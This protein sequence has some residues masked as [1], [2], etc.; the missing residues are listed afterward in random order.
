[1][2][3]MLALN[4]PQFDWVKTRFSKK[5]QP[6]PPIYQPEV[7]AEAIVWMANHDRTELWVGLSTV[8]AIVGNRIIPRWLDHLLARS[9]WSSQLTDEEEGP[10]REH[11]LW[12]PVDDDIDYG[13]HGRFDGKAREQSYQLWAATHRGTVLAVVVA[14]VGLLGAAFARLRGS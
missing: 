14:L 5:P 2:V 1:M 6:V 8:K 9:G 11:N 10:D 3:E 13:V 7:A 12:E 4:T